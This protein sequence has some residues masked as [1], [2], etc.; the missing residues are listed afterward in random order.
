MKG[1]R[2]IIFAIITVNSLQLTGQ[3]D[4]D[5]PASP[6]LNIV[7]VNQITNNVEVSWSTS[8]SAD[9]SGYVIYL[10][11]NNEGYALDTIRNPLITSYTRTGS[12]AAFYSESFVVAAFDTA[13]NIS[14]LSNALNTIYTEAEIDT[15]NKRME[16]RWNSYPS[17]P[18][19]VYNYS[20]YNSLDG[21]PFNI[22]DTVEAERNTFLINDFDFNVGYCFIVMANLEN[23][24]HSGSNSF[25]L[26]TAMQRPPQW[27]NADYA[28]VDENNE[29]ILSFKIDPLSEISFF[30]L[31]RKTS[32]TDE[33]RPLHQFTS[34]NTSLLYSDKE[35][36][37]SRIN[38]YRLAAVNNCGNP[39]IYSNIASNIVLSLN[40]NDDNIELRWNSYRDWIGNVGSYKLFVNTG[41]QF[42]E[43]DLIAAGDTMINIRY[44]DFMY[45]IKGGDACFI[46][47]AY[48]ASNPYGPAGES[49]SSVICIP[50]TENVFIPNTFTPDGNDIND[51]FCP[52]LS[53]TPA[54]YHLL[55][56]DLRR[57]KV[58]ETRS[59]TEE[60]DGKLNGNRL[61]Q[62]VYLWFL[63]I[64]TPSG[65]NFSKTGTVTIIDN[66]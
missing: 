15:C 9:V 8:T 48:E 17:I 44:S 42:V 61:P 58:F 66:R 7:T 64:I 36:D 52:V 13:G 2:Y 30:S 37:I 35:A 45:E 47:K 11:R 28:T 26:F 63:E 50:T 49:R 38:Y 54:N 25:C 34:V 51:Y 1:F 3:A 57:N 53:F 21:G 20:V 41:T 65:R 27:I 46:I 23:G 12:G 55:I 32:A 14:P 18:F 16:I 4:T 22:I 59:H 31:E 24:Q 10:Y 60:W 62:G 33:F 40:L 5:P 56:T 43:E 19:R 39:I 6:V 29:I